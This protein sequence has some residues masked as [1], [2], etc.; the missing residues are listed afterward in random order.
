MSNSL[1]KNKVTKDIIN[2]GYPSNLVKPITDDIII[3]NE[4][5]I[6]RKEIEK[7]KRKLSRKY[8]GNE[9]NKRIKYNLYKKGFNL[10]YID[11]LL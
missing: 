9:L 10:E 1:F 6:L 5:D 4:L 7:E 3:D 2:L 11:S 8:E